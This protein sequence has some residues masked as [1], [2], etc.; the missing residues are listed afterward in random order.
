MF[1]SIQ[2]EDWYKPDVYMY[3]DLIIALAKCKKM[4][5]AMEIWNNMRDEKLFP[6]S[7]TYAEVIRGFLR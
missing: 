3:K 7:Q 2:K 4:D 5:V 6:D 1:R